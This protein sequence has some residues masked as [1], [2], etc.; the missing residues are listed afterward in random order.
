MLSSLGITNC[1]PRYSTYK[2]DPYIALEHTWLLT[3]IFAVASS[4]AS[5]V[6]AASNDNVD[7][8]SRGAG[9]AAIWSTLMIFVLSWFLYKTL[10]DWRSPYSVGFSIGALLSISQLFLCLFGVFAGIA[11]EAREN[12]RKNNSEKQKKLAKDD[13]AMAALSFIMFVLYFVFFV[14]LAKYR[15]FVVLEEPDDQANLRLD[16]HESLRND[17]QS[18]GLNR[19]EKENEYDEDEYEDQDL[20][21]GSL[22]SSVIPTQI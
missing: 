18:A 1:P 21:E 15:H 20:G 6:A 14:M 16:D 19:P 9:F 17:D 22:Q 7:K 11:G 2:Q 5:L 4:I 13:S 3:T 10:K 8:G 12:S